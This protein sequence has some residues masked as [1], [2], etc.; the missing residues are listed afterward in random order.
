MAHSAPAPPPVGQ[1]DGISLFYALL[2]D[3]FA[4]IHLLNLVLNCNKI[5]KNVKKKMVF[6]IVYFLLTVRT[7][8][9]LI[10]P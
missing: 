9:D 10:L 7:Q 5:N 4:L 1:L 8:H 2:G 3:Q 6:G